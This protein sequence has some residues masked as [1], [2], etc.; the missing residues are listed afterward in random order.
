MLVW[1]LVSF[2]H[3]FLSFRWSLSLIVSLTR[4]RAHSHALGIYSYTHPTLIY[5]QFLFTK[6]D[7]IYRWETIS[8]LRYE[9]PHRRIFLCSFDLNPN[10]ATTNSYNF[11]HTI[12]CSGQFSEWNHCKWT[13][14]SIDGHDTYWRQL[15]IHHIYIF[16][17]FLLLL[18]SFPSLFFFFNNPSN[19]LNVRMI[20][21]L[22]M[23]R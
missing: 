17:F 16:F 23:R 10:H 8:F 21:K 22:K 19:N 1:A 9:F 12:F 11:I 14:R 3:S 6:T 7:A 4:A 2:V 20:L 18:C 5:T 13:R 15:D